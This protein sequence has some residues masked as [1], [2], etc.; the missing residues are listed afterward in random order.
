MAPSAGNITGADLENMADHNNSSWDDVIPEVETYLVGNGSH[1]NLSFITNGSHGNVS[2]DDSLDHAEYVPYP[3]MDLRATKVIY[4]IVLPI[5]CTCGILGILIT[6]FVLSHKNMRT[7]TNC[8]LMALS[9]ADL[10]FLSLLA[11]RLAENQFQPHTHTYYIYQIYSTY[12]TELGNVCLLASIWLTVMLAVER[13]IAVCKPFLATKLCTVARARLSIIL[14][15]VICL[16]LRLV[17]FWQYKVSSWW[18]PGS[19]TTMYYIEHV[20]FS[21]HHFWIPYAWIVDLFIASVIPFTLLLVMNALLILAVRRSTKYL[22]SNQLSSQ[23]TSAV[24]REELQITVML[25]SVVIVFFICQA[26]YVIYVAVTNVR[27]YDAAI[28]TVSF[29]RF[30]S[31]AMLLLT[32]KSAVNFVLYCW[33]SES[34][35]A[36]LRRTACGKYCFK[37]VLRRSDSEY[38]HRRFSSTATNN[39]TM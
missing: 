2:L 27:R 19:N 25:I 20:D 18:I 7:S 30:N 29:I 31:A 33:F 15:F 10:L 11:P 35:W 4:H 37:K 1:G 26:P 22:Q 24:Q 39:T 6:M 8:Y 32:L 9:V 23:K 12:S 13:Y 38:S 17:N 28:M 14:I 34:F 3:E 21:Y 16:L 5:I 36:T